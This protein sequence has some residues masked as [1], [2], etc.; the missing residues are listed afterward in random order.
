MDNKRLMLAMVVGL[1]LM[2]GWLSLVQYLDKAN[3]HWNLMGRATT[4]P[5]STPAAATAPPAGP[6]PLTVPATGATTAPGAPEQSRPTPTITTRPADGALSARGGVPAS[7]LPP[8][9]LG[10]AASDDGAFAMAVE[11]DPRG[12]GVRQVTL[13]S[14]R[15]AVDS[16]ARYVF[17]TPASD[18]RGLGTPVS[19]EAL[20]DATRVLAMR[21]ITVNGQAVNLA[22]LDWKL[23][24]SDPTS[25]VFS[26]EVVR[27]EVP[28]V[29]LQRSFTLTA[30]GDASKGYEVAVATAVANLTGEP[31]TTEVAINGPGAPPY[32]IERGPE[33][34]LVHGYLDLNRGE[35]NVRHTMAESLTTERQTVDLTRDGASPDPL[36][37]FGTSGAYFNALLRPEPLAGSPTGTVTADWVRKVEG[38]VYNP[39]EKD[40]HLREIYTSMESSAIRLEPGQSVTL[41]ARVYFGPKKRDILK[42][43]YYAA[44]PLS[45]DQTLVMTTWLC[46]FCT[47]Q[48]LIGVLVV[49]L[50]AFHVVVRDWGVAIILLVVVVRI[51][52]HPITR[53]SQENMMKMGKMG[54]EIE[55]LKKKYG[56]NKDELNKAMMQFYKEQGA[57][58]I[59]GCLPMFLQM[60]IWIALYAALQSTFELRQAP[61]FY[62]LTWIHDLSKP[63]H[64]WNFGTFMLF[65]FLPFSGLNLI[66]FLLAIVFYL[67]FKFTPKPP[68]QT[69]EQIQ[70]Q[71]M[72]QWMTPL[73]PIFLYNMPAGLNIYI[74]TSTTFGIIENKLI[75]D[76]LKRKEALEAEGKVVVDASPTRQSRKIRAGGKPVEPK[77]KGLM[78]WLEEM[79]QRAEEIRNQQNKKKG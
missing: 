52:L 62:N 58:P 2:L 3:P 35:V 5:A 69:P 25:A 31:L 79:Q 33:R 66:P 74:L 23:E 51:L 19:A 29:R 60:P 67:Q 65:G 4:Q 17:Q 39:L 6:S 47:F 16:D 28:V 42:T 15:K 12:A 7:A 57:T 24:S 37:W 9:V 11:L 71:K 41:P 26:A 68:V 61:F 75:R 56:D 36:G 72:M 22:S 44:F 77:R 20:A 10:S 59:L 49:M 1:I 73:F 45:Y 76:A 54:P 30:R 78:G 21:S 46:S 55:R 63:D 38:R 27:G 14:F 43:D 53:K 8:V 32:E 48:W 64:L 70:Q 40:T 18:T 50:N 34:Q 13:N